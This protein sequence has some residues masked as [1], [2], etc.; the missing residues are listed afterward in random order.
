MDMPSREA[1][2]S[3]GCLATSISKSASTSAC[4]AGVSSIIAL[5]GY[6]TACP[7]SL[8][9]PAA[10]SAEP[11]LHCCYVIFLGAKNEEMKYPGY[12]QRDEENEEM[13]HR[14]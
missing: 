3:A 1:A 12:V 6:E 13:K 5:D 14:Y 2:S 9:A 11:F 4:V 7:V 8:L 10:P